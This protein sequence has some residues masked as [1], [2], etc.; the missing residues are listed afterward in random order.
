MLDIT[1]KFFIAKQ[2]GTF[3]EKA[4]GKCEMEK[5]PHALHIVS[6]PCPTTPTW[7]ISKCACAQMQPK[8]TLNLL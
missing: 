2:S 3:R 6:Q 4:L 8:F 7:M 1:F 5:T